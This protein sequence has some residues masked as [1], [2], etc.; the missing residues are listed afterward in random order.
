MVTNNFFAN[1]GASSEQTLLEDLIIESIK[2]Y[3]DNHYYVTRTINNFDHLYGEDDQSTYNSAYLIEMYMKS[4]DGF[5]G[6]GVFMSKFGLQIRDQVVFSVARRTFAQEVGRYT[7]FTRP[8]EGDLIYMPVIQKVFTVQYVDPREMFY[9]LGSLQ[10]FELTCELFEYSSEKFNTGIPEIDI[11][12]VKFSQNNFD[13]TLKTEDGDMLKTE[14]N[15]YL[16]VEKNNPIVPV[17]EGNNA[18]IQEES[19][20]ILDWTETDPFSE[21]NL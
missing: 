17:T 15:D 3:G 8:R 2:I 11:L 12:Q 10:T 14:D 7:Q 5:S 20:V 4:V 21:G 9:Q 19:D 18:K 16:T 13:Y 1:Y 6:D